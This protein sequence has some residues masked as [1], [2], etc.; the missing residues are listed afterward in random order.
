MV[1]GTRGGMPGMGPLTASSV[2][3]TPKNVSAL[4]L[5]WTEMALSFKINQI[6]EFLLLH[7][8]VSSSYDR[9]AP[10]GVKTKI[11]QVF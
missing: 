2:L 8:F 11:V 3:L 4:G 5:V 6:L 1:T 9:A 10:G 7:V